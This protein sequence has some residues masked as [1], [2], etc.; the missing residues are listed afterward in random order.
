MGGYG[1]AWLGGSLDENK[2]LSWDNGGTTSY[3]AWARHRP[4]SVSIHNRL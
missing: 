1:V 4:K 2:V 3:T